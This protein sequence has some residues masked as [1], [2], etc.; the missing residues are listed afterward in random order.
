MWSE[1]DWFPHF[2]LPLSVLEQRKRQGGALRCPLS[3]IPFLPGVVQFLDPSSISIC[4]RLLLSISCCSLRPT[5]RSWPPELRTDAPEPEPGRSHRRSDQ[6]EGDWTWWGTEDKG[7]YQ[8]VQQEVAQNDHQ[9]TENKK[10]VFDFPRRKEAGIYT[11]FRMLLTN[12]PLHRTGENTVF[13]LRRLAS[14]MISKKQQCRYFIC[15]CWSVFCSTLWWCGRGWDKG[16]SLVGS[17]SLWLSISCSLVLL[18]NCYFGG[19][20]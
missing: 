17:P 12:I 13:F 4:S 9:E 2:Y 6:G 1:N 3:F 15:L 5:Q 10:G 8:M 16:S 20:G 7:F 18:L 14:F 11:Y 19:G